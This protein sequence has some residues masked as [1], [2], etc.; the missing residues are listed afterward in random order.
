MGWKYER[1]E[2]MLM[3]IDGENLKAFQATQGVCQGSI[4]F[5]HSF[6]MYGEFG[7][8]WNLLVVYLWLVSNSSSS[9]IKGGREIQY[10]MA[11]CEAGTY[12][13]DNEVS[14]VIR[15]SS[16]RQGII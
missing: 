7:R 5:P 11:L 10:Q 16:S 1:K 15:G 13:E 4:L 3:R 14:H 6:I 8:F 9:T 2:V 12:N